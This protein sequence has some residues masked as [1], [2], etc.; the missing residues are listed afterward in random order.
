MLGKYIKGRGKGWEKYTIRLVSGKNIIDL[1]KLRKVLGY[2][3]EG[4]KVA[5]WFL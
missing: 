1:Y 3:G 4:V 2:E 5:Y